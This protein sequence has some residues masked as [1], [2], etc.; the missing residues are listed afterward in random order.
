MT[1]E[2]RPSCSIDALLSR[3]ETLADVRAFFAVRNVVE[4]DTP[5]LSRTTVTD[6][7]IDS[8]SLSSGGFVYYLQTSPEYQMKRLLAAGA[9]SIVRIGPVF[10]AGESGRLHNP[11]FTM[12]EWYRREYDLGG[13]IDEV[14]ALVDAV[15]GAAPY[16]RMRYFDLLHDAAQIDAWR[17]TNAS[18]AAALDRLGIEVSPRAALTRRD[19]LDLLA[20]Y[21][22][23]KLGDGRVFITD[24][25]PDQAALARVVDGPDGR[26]VAQRF[27]LVIDGVEIANGYHELTAPD[28]LAA[29][30]HHERTVRAA[31]GRS[32]PAADERLLAALRE[33]LPE[34]SGVALGFD[35]LL[36]LKLGAT[37][38][39]AV[40]PFSLARC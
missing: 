31:A 27:E 16:R 33:G 34:C 14:G 30:M 3:A 32:A 6:P 29:R 39:D 2:W 26:A 38:I 5:V 23:R 11:E 10:R 22:L 24:Y 4:I 15:L 12:I 21:A 17:S 36:M 19:R 25:P 28:E 35:R 13:L 40:L 9:P 1:E 18:L 7:A 37:S 20:E 8:L